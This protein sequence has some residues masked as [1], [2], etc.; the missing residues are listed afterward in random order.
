M[1]D[2]AVSGEMG[3]LLGGLS[4][5]QE[6]Y[7]ILAADVTAGGILYYGSFNGT[8]VCTV[9]PLLVPAL[10]SDKPKVDT[11]EMQTIES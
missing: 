7:P 2:T 8:R 3:L 9:F 1:H 11:I 6:A 5:G 10:F 4:Q